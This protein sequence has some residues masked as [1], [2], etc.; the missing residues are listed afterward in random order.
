MNTLTSAKSLILIY[1]L[2]DLECPALRKPHF[3]YFTHGTTS[4][5]LKWKCV[6]GEGVLPSYF[7][8]L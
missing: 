8:I 3:I 5:C 4:V 7:L 2:L 6:K 1:S